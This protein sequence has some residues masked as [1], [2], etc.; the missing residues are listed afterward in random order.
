MGAIVLT[1]ALCVT[2]VVSTLLAPV[3]GLAMPEQQFRD[4][5]RSILKSAKTEE[6]RQ[7]IISV[8]AQRLEL[9]KLQVRPEVPRE[10]FQKESL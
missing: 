10:I 7:K 5:L 9:E 3:R 1:F 6:E 8:I 2:V 4:H